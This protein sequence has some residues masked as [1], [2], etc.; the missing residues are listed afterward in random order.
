MPNRR[1]SYSKVITN[2]SDKLRDYRLFYHTSVVAVVRLTPGMSGNISWTGLS[3]RLEDEWH[4][5]YVEVVEPPADF[6]HFNMVVVRDSPAGA[7]AQERWQA[8]YDAGEG[9]ENATQYW[10]QVAYEC[11]LDKEEAKDGA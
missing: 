5:D 7:R 1:V 4:L 9:S 2:D 6:R 10:M 11:L 3:G 8:I